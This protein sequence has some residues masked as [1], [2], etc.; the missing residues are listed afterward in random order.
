MKGIVR[1]EQARNSGMESCPETHLNIDKFSTQEVV[2]R[3]ATRT[4]LYS[5]RRMR[6]PYN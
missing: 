2:L 1:G 4:A 6:N 3:T 5:E